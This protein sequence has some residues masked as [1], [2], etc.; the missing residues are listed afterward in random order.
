MI[1]VAPEQHQSRVRGQKNQTRAIVHD[2]VDGVRLFDRA[3]T[4]ERARARG[5]GEKIR[6]VK[7]LLRGEETDVFR[8]ASC[9]SVH[10]H[11]AS[12][13]N[14]SIERRED[15]VRVRDRRRGGRRHDGVLLTPKI[16]EGDCAARRASRARTKR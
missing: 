3:S 1:D 14:E 13:R 15:V 6:Q 8:R 16:S 4:E 10:L 2:C 5:R 12:Q 7:H 9:D 11:D